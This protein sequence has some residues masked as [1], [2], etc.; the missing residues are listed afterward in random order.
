MPWSGLLRLAA[1]AALWHFLQ[2]SQH[3]DGLRIGALTL[4]LAAVV[5][6]DR[7]LT[8][9]WAA[10]VPARTGRLLTAALAL[11]IATASLDLARSWTISVRWQ[12]RR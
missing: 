11:W 3:F 9:R 2:D 10:T 4:A 12:R 1:L 6:L 8:A 5:V 7:P